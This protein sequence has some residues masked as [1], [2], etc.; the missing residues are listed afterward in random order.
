M[1]KEPNGNG[2]EYANKL[3]LYSIPLPTFKLKP[4]RYIPPKKT[5]LITNHPTEP[6]KE[7]TW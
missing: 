3:S 4:E 5:S 1:A 7:R 2:H 6:P